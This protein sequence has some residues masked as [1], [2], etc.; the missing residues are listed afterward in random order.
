MGAT[1]FSTMKIGRFNTAK[2]AYN[3][4]VEDATHEHGHDPYNGTI[5]TTDS[6]K[7]VTHHRPRLETRAFHDWLDGQFDNMG[8]REC[9][10]IA[11]KPSE[12]RREKDANGLKGQRGISAYLFYGWA[13]E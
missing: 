5:S 4:A 1:T 13:A 10:C 8:K 6:F 7:M 12:L 9:R 11:L 2:A 3:Q